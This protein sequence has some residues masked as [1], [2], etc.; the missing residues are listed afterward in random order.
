MKIIYCLIG[1]FVLCPI[2]AYSSDWK[3]ISYVP[4]VISVTDPKTGEPITVYPKNVGECQSKI[5]TANVKYLPK[6]HVR[7][8]K[9]T[10]LSHGDKGH[11]WRKDLYE[12]DCVNKKW[13]Y[14]QIG[15]DALTDSVPPEGP[16]S[17]YWTEPDSLENNLTKYVCKH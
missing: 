5:D 8:W 1:L 4:S 9:S 15:F 2:M 16:S 13:R 10:K 17:W 11:A 7:V 3:C 6:G 12:I 14:L